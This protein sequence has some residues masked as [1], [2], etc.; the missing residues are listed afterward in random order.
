MTQNIIKLDKKDKKIIALMHDQKYSQ[1]EMAKQIQLSQP[2]VAMR[3]KKLKD[4]GIVD[5]ITG[6]NLSK[7]GLYV[8]LVMVRTTNPGKIINMIKICPFFLN[9][10]VTTGKENLILLLAG[11]DL[12][13]LQSIIDYRIRS[14]N[15]V[16]SA[17]FNIMISSSNDFVMPLN[18]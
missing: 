17:D 6:V 7:I 10:F 14:D 15:D 8:A 1:E 9:G 2:S 18:L 16:Q 11:E 4:R 3:I 5:N 12:S 13:S